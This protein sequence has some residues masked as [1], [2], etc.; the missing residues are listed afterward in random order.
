MLKSVS[1]LD[2]TDSLPGMVE[3]VEFLY[4]PSTLHESRHIVIAL[5]CLII[6]W[7]SSF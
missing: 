3:A 2:A 7:S 1:T 4:L 6:D 5:K